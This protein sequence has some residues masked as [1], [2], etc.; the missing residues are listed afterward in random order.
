[1]IVPTGCAVDVADLIRWSSYV[2][3]QSG[4]IIVCAHSQA[5]VTYTHF[6]QHSFCCH[7]SISCFLFAT[8]TVTFDFW[9]LISYSM[10]Y[11]QSIIHFCGR[12]KIGFRFWLF[13]LWVCRLWLTC[14]EFFHKQH[15]LFNYIHFRVEIEA[16]VAMLVY[17]GQ[18]FGTKL[19]RPYREL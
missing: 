16:L 2:L 19:V 1:M 14:V 12:K 8:L 13:L 5:I 3:I 7:W 4:H 6:L 15:S 9:V 18:S 11:D 17:S 10:W